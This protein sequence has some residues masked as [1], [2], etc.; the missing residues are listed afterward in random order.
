MTFFLNDLYKA[1][2]QDEFVQAAC[3]HNSTFCYI[4]FFSASGEAILGTQRYL[5]VRSQYVLLYKFF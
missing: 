5:Y 1:A 3:L 2:G 4:K